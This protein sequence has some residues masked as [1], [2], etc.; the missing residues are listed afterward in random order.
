VKDAAQD[1]WERAD[2]LL[3]EALELPT[4][5]REDFVRRET[6]G[7]PALAAQ[8][9]RLLR[10]A[11]TPDRLLDGP[12]IGNDTTWEQ[13]VEA[14]AAAAPHPGAAADELLGQQLGPYQIVRE[15]GRGG[16]AVV[17]L[18]RRT[19]GA[20][21]QEVAIKVLER[22]F[23]TG[24]MRLRFG[25]ERQ[26]L[27]A[28]NHPNLARIYDSGETP[29][30]R[31]YF[32]MER[33]EGRRIDRYADEERL[34][35]RERVELVVA[36]AHAV[37]DAHRRLVVH[38][39]IKPSNILVATDGH[40]KLL[41]FGIAKLLAAPEGD[42]T[43]TTA[44]LMT[45]G[46]AAPEQIRGEEVTTATDVYQLGLL[47]YELLTGVP[48]YDTKNGGRMA[49]E[50][51]ICEEPPMRLL[52]AVRSQGDETARAE[53][54][55][56][57]PAELRR[58]LRG[59]L[60]AILFKALAK[61]PESRYISVTEL[62]QDLERYLDGRP[63]RA[64][65]PTVGYQLRRFVGRHRGAVA[66]A[67]LFLLLLIA[68]AVSMS[69]QARQLAAER[70]RANREAKTASEVADFLAA[71]FRDANPART[72]KP[73]ISARELLDR[74]AARLT[75]SEIPDPLVRARLQLVIGNVYRNL[76]LYPK[77]EALLMP[78]VASLAA[79]AGSEAP[80]TLRARKELVDVV[81]LSGRMEEARRLAEE[82]LPVEIRVFGEEAWEVI[83]SRERLAE[84]AHTQ[85]RLRDAEALFRATLKVRQ[86][87]YGS[88]PGVT[89]YAAD[90]LARVLLD[91]RQLAEA[92]SLTR[93]AIDGYL[94]RIGPDHPST[95][96]AHAQLGEIAHRRGDLEAAAQHFA[97]AVPRLAEVIGVEHPTTLTNVGRQAQVEHSRGHYAEALVLHRQGLEGLRRV[98]GIDHPA[99][100][101]AAGYALAT[102]VAVGE[103]A[104]AEKLGNEVVANLRRLVGPTSPYTL[105]AEVRCA[106]MLDAIGRDRAAREA[107][108]SLVERVPAALGHDHF[109]SHLAWVS[110]AASAARQGRPDEAYALLD[111]AANAGAIEPLTHTAFD[112]LREQPAFR[113]IVERF[114][115]NRRQRG[116]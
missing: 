99:T 36:V 27:A 80:E 29:D 73:D 37:E 107:F 10:A 25:R 7:N 3:E 20:F 86:E 82:L 97:Y 19:D 41:D 106:A 105:A 33:V 11:D 1:D 89:A 31:P 91:R 46:Y 111:R 112:A 62:A 32:V 47:L 8:L 96:L 95:I 100:H 30:G 102:L 26:I 18:A 49:I 61:A 84:I 92:E 5:E 53:R 101:I 9:E 57:T 104:E 43:R 44:R 34:P 109:A 65:V 48:P 23:S 28:S 15:L 116:L 13:P 85:G 4:G 50:E 115:A 35:V 71:V 110:A 87:R 76:A 52:S 22:G 103:V 90:R 94:V 69:W 88:E 78:A 45:P 42:A 21:E 72:R 38:R 60:E 12:A 16:M 113:A 93:G 6:A 55:A 64:Q 68:Y 63:V 66:G 40:P 59:D 83:S 81:H 51:R 75:E 14:T 54:R 56:T 98:A 2:R 114:A 79:A 67:S 24:E 17:Y 74:G 108:A 39:D 58:L 77:A 70:D